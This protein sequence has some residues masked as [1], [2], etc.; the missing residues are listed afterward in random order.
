MVKLMS[1][2]QFPGGDA[3]TTTSRTRDLLLAGGS[4]VRRMARVAGMRRGLMAGGMATAGGGARRP[5][6]MGG[7]RW[8]FRRLRLWMRFACCV[9]GGARRGFGLLGNNRKRGNHS[10]TKQDEESPRSSRKLSKKAATIERPGEAPTW[11]SK[12]KK[13][14]ISMNLTGCCAK[15]KCPLANSHLRRRFVRNLVAVLPSNQLQWYCDFGAIDRA[16]WRAARSKGPPS[17]HGNHVDSGRKGSK[18]AP[19]RP[20]AG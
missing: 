14:H 18:C 20:V 13:L 16:R 15:T 7:F 11:Q 1:A 5:G 12:S 3:V 4:L 8:M 19:P 17:N 9:R 6:E 2:S 10:K